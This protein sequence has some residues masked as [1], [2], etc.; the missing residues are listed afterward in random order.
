[1]P[2]VCLRTIQLLVLAGLAVMAAPRQAP[3][4]ELGC[5]AICVYD[6]WQCIF[7]TGHPADPCG[8]DSSQDICN[9]GS[10]DVSHVS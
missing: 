2:R 1:M 8:Y 9:L 5:Y 10:C 6:D 3:A 4:N 7:E